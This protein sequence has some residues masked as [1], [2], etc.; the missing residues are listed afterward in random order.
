M[1]T[2]LH[3]YI[4]TYV[5]TSIRTYIHTYIQTHTHTHIRTHTHTFVC[6]CRQPSLGLQALTHQ[7]TVR[8][9]I[10]MTDIDRIPLQQIFSNF[11]LIFGAFISFQFTKD[12]MHIHIHLHVCVLFPNFVS[13]HVTSPCQIGTICPC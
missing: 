11:I 3:T 1:H 4:H 2:Y 10:F 13:E 5:H 12:Y 8:T 7:F 9:V 6:C